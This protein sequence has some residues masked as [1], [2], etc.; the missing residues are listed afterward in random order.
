VAQKTAGGN[1]NEAWGSRIG[2]I[3][4]MAGNAVGLGNFLRFPGQAAANGG[5]SFMITYFIAFL[6]LGIPL[7]WIEWGLGRN[8]GRYRKGHIPGMFAA[9]WRHPASKYL[10]FIGLVIPFVVM[11]SYVILISW[12]LAFAFF[13]ITGD[14]WGLT[15][16]AE[17]AGYLASYQVIRDAS[18]HD[19]WVPFVFYFISLFITIYVLSKGISGGI[20]KLAKF[21]MPVLFFFAVILAVTVFFL[22]PGPDG[23]TALTGFQFIFNPDLSRL[24][25]ATVWLASAGQIFFTLSIG[26]GTLQTYASYLSTKDDIALSGLATAATNETA[27]VVLGGSIAIPAAVTFFG[28]S[29]A[30][31]VAQ[32]GSFNIGFVSMPVVFQQMPFGQVFGTMWFSLLFFAG[33]T[34]S[35]AMGTPIV[36]F[37]REEFGY[38]RETVAWILGAVTMTFG[39]WTILWFEYQFLWEWDYW[40]GTFGLVVMA[41]IEVI[42]FMWVFK[43]ERAWQSIH[44]GA[45]IRIP[46]IFKFIMTYMTP[47]YLLILLAWWSVT[48]ALPILRIEGGVAAGGPIIP[49]TERYVHISRLIIAGFMVLALILIRLAWKQNKY[50][51]RAGLPVI[52]GTPLGQPEVVR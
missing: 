10:G 52:E 21:G 26:M 4:A 6:L 12:T 24:G 44:E 17:M 3:L 49:G 41:T 39:L 34:S 43:P 14:Y 48:Q 35:V 2:L 7:M 27:E 23:S 16:Q 45:D 5:G 50:D 51:D 29:G 20:E 25:D 46:G 19:F 40:A 11:T 13:S 31:A 28:V 8:G 30:M 22:P 36:A 1:P 38:R 9:I 33:I 37:F 18:V 32:S 47:V 42:L 15:T